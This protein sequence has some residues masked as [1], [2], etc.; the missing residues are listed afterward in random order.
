MEAGGLRQMVPLGISRSNRCCRIPNSFRPRILAGTGLFFLLFIF[1]FLSFL[2]QSRRLLRLMRITPLPL[3]KLTSA[4]VEDDNHSD[5]PKPQTFFF[6]FMVWLPRF[7]NIRR[8]FIASPKKNK[9]TNTLIH[10][11]I[12]IDKCIEKKS[13]FRK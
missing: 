4:R 9:K 1:L 3:L 2:F 13:S 12:H 6:N 8:F 11:P 5:T 10:S 7:R